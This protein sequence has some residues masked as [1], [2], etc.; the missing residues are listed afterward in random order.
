MK[1]LITLA[2]IATFSLAFN[3]NSLVGVFKK[4]VN[5]LSYT[6]ATSGINPRVYEFDTQ[7]YPRMHCVVVFRDDP[8]AAPAM[9]CIETKPEYIKMN[10]KLK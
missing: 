3:W 7:G 8:K 5:T 9:Q 4:T 1:K 10:E 6:I 2:F